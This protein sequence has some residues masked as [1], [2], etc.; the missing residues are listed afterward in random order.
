MAIHLRN[1]FESSDHADGV[2]GRGEQSFR[3]F[4]RL[5]CLRVSSHS[6]QRRALTQPRLGKGE[7]SAARL[8]FV[9]RSAASLESFRKGCDFG[10][11]LGFEKEDSRVGSRGRRELLQFI[12]GGERLQGGLSPYEKETVV[13]LVGKRAP[14]SGV[15]SSRLLALLGASDVAG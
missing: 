6:S 8:G 1:F 3:P 2:G 9:R 12:D 10:A 14:Q 7:T 4:Q 11:R 5:E 13:E 15:D